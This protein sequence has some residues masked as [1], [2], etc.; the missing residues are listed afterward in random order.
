MTTL[1]K[2]AYQTFD[3]RNLVIPYFFSTK[4]VTDVPGYF[5]RDDA[6]QIW[7]AIRTFTRKVL[8]FYYVGDGELRADGELQTWLRE[9]HDVGLPYDPV[10]GERRHNVPSTFV[11]CDELVTFV[12]AIIFACTAQQ[13]A[14]SAGQLD[15]YGFCPNAPMA[16]FRPPM[17]KKGQ[18]DMK[19]ILSA[20]GDM[21]AI[22]SQA[23][24]AVSLTQVTD[25]E[26]R[27]GAVSVESFNDV[28]VDEAALRFRQRLGEIED[29]ITQRNSGLRCP[30]CYLKPSKIPTGI[31]V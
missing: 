15:A 14:L 16:M 19:T 8:G 11:T 10:K 1:L 9:I 3:F 22:S 30:Y 27:L 2:H 26:V 7:H 17:V 24:L 5:Y 13:S 28:R 21:D 29:H 6:L 20:L 23:A 12:T 31:I 4:G 25:S 18:V